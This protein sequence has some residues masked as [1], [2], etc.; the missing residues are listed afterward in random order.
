M[1]IPLTFPTSPSSLPKSICRQVFDRESS[2]HTSALLAT[3]MESI[4]LPSRLHQLGESGSGSI[5]GSLNTMEAGLNGNGNQKIGSVQMSIVDPATLQKREEEKLSN[6]GGRGR[7]SDDLMRMQGRSNKESD[8]EATNS[9]ATKL[10]IDFLPR[11]SDELLRRTSHS[12][13]RH[14]KHRYDHEQSRGHIFGQVETLRGLG[15]GGH[16]EADRH[17]PL[18]DNG[19]NRMPRRLAALPILEKYV[20]FLIVFSYLPHLHVRCSINFSIPLFVFDLVA[21]CLCYVKFTVRRAWNMRAHLHIEI[22]CSGSSVRAWQLAR[23]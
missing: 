21:M 10:D 8:H 18:L 5:A 3:V 4:S 7:K 16:D 2:W 14:R 11:W 13:R 22:S 20:L 23:N 6:L 15:I 19:T 9:H 1:Y 17:E 12:D